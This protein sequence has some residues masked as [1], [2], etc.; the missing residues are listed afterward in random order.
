MLTG[1]A[2]AIFSQTR[3]QTLKDQVEAERSNPVQIIIIGAQ[4]ALYVEV[5]GMLP[6]VTA[7]IDSVACWIPCWNS[8]G[9]PQFSNTP[10]RQNGVRS[11]AFELVPPR[12]LPSRQE[13][14][15]DTRIF[16]LDE[17]LLTPRRRNQKGK[18]APPKRGWI[19]EE[20]IGVRGHQ[21]TYYRETTWQP[22]G[23]IMK[24][25]Q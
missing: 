10:D 20:S 2:G 15:V 22:G 4:E 13:R 16:W 17:L 3:R 6:R 25:L 24:N 18:K 23:G 11:N 21:W 12:W 5:A 8:M 14:A 19:W 1:P 7:K 9:F